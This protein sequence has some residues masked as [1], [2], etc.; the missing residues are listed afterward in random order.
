MEMNLERSAQKQQK[1]SKAG[2]RR[3]S[4]EAAG[5]DRIVRMG[6]WRRLVRGR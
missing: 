5:E 3:L 6:S 2:H 4:R 1:A